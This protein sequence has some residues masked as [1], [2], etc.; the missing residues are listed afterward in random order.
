MMFDLLGVETCLL[1][2]CCMMFDLL[3]VETCLLDMCCMMFVLLGVETCLLD[4][5]CM[6][7]GLFG[8][9]TCLLDT[10]HVYR[11]YRICIDILLDIQYNWNCPPICNNLNYK[12]PVCIANL[13]ALYIGRWIWPA[14]YTSP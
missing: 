4:M 11:I 5:C 10:V 7:F 2:M 12:W 8:V 1:D 3:G 9:E 6:M 13:C 14:L